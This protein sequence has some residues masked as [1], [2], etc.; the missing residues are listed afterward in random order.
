M[1][2][3]TQV[4]DGF[5]RIEDGKGHQIVLESCQDGIIVNNSTHNPCLHVFKSTDGKPDK[6]KL[7]LTGPGG[8]SDW[9]NFEL[10]QTINGK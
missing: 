5:V 3:I 7:L 2:K 8:I 9:Q 1:L 10:V 6:T 4:S